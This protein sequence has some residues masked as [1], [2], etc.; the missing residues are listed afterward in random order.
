MGCLR[1][2]PGVQI[3]RLDVGGGLILA[4]L[5]R[6][7]AHLSFDLDVTSVTDGI[8]SGPLDPHKKGKAVDVRSRTLSTAAKASVLSL[9]MGYLAEFTEQ[10]QGKPRGS[11]TLVST[12]GG[13]ATPLFFGFLEAPGTDN[14]HFHLQV[15]KG[16]EVLRVPG[17]LNA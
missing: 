6:T 10:L 5:A 12:S 15:R 3:D 4:A 11:V 2:K 13:F 16:H 8:H 1:F 17:A 9:V 14:E 7:A